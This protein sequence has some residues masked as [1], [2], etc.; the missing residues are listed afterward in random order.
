MLHRQ[1]RAKRIARRSI[2]QSMLPL[3][4]HLPL[5]WS[6]RKHTLWM[7]ARRRQRVRQSKARARQSKTRAGQRKARLAR[8][9]RVARVAR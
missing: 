3:P 4:L 7:K 9:A 1:Q 5:L 8:L 2:P 6:L